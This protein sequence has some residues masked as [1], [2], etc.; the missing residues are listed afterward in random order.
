[1]GS[2]STSAPES[3]NGWM[4]SR[5]WPMTSVGAC[6][7]RRCALW[8]AVRPKN[9]P[10]ST[11]ALGPGSWRTVSST[12]VEQQRPAAGGHRA[13]AARDHAHDP[14]AEGQRDQQRREGDRDTEQR[15]V[16]HGHLDDHAAHALRRERGR[17]E[18][19]VGAQ[20]RTRR[21]PPRRP[22]GGRASAIICSPKKLIEYCGHVA[23]A[24]RAAVTEQVERDDAV[25]ALGQG[26]GERLV[27]LLRQQQ[28]VDEHAGAR[29]LPVDRV[30]QAVARV[31]EERHRR[32]A[33]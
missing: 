25:A 4:G 24:V 5:W 2:S 1:M 21:G 13:G 22:R 29:P 16:E 7:V 33:Q 8:G 18:R 14:L 17:L 26:R 12:D 32:F 3:L 27:H 30:G 6:N 10:C 28:P 9:R 20:R 23:R 11:A 15:V 31:A 19:G